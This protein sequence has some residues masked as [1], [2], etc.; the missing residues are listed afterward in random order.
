MAAAA[1]GGGGPWPLFFLGDGASMEELLP[2]LGG[3]QEEENSWLLV[4]C[5]E[6]RV[7]LHY[8]EVEMQSRPWD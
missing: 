4:A 7:S 6:N 2:L 1:L 3:F 8:I 5:L